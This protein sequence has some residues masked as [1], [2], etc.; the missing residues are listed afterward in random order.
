MTQYLGEISW[1][2][3]RNVRTT[4]QKEANR[5]AYEAA[6]GCHCD[7]HEELIRMLENQ[8][9]ASKL[10]IKNLQQ[11]LSGTNLTNEIAELMVEINNVLNMKLLKDYN[12]NASYHD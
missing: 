9:R 10:M 7:N 12:G 1:R 5:L 6:R 4:G 3:V 8:A 11:G 2:F